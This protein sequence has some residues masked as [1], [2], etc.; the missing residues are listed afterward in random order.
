LIILGNQ[1]EPV[2]GASNGIQDLPFG[3]TQKTAKR[4]ERIGAFL[5]LDAVLTLE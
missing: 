4:T 5:A 2:R 3:R 1:A